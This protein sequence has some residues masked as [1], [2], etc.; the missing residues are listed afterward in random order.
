MIVSDHL[1]LKW[2]LSLQDPRERLAR[3]AMEV[4]SFDFEISYEKGPN[5][6]VPDTLSLDAVRLQP[7]T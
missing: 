5:L 3:W 7:R 4:Q 6:V 1:A 2:L